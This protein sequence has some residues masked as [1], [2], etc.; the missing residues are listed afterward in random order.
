M[1][2][3]ALTTLASI[4]LLAACG[5]ET[6]A[7]AENGAY[8]TI[9]ALNF[10]RAKVPSN[11]DLEMLDGDLSAYARE[12][13][14]LDNRSIGAADKCALF[15][16]ADA[17]GTLNGFVAIRQAHAVTIVTAL[18]TDILKGGLGCFLAG[19]LESTDWQT[20]NP[21]IEIS[22]NFNARL[23]YIAWEKSPGNWMVSTSLEST[24]QG[25]VGMWYVKKQG[26]KL[27][28][29][30]ERWSYCYSNPAV[31]IDDV[32]DHALTLSRVTS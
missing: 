20:P 7:S 25:A 12:L 16:R 8:E 28:I 3:H 27:R 23:G 19:T 17:S 5:L 32:F 29:N 26:N 4:A 13:C 15:V 14:D 1:K 2:L 11:S 31:Y 30:Q 21:Q 22:Q 18:K 6:T 24:D 9:Y 10:D